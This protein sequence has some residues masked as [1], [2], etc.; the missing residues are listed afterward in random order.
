MSRWDARLSRMVDGD[1]KSFATRD[2]PAVE[3]DPGS[4]ALI[5]GGTPHTHSCKAA[6]TVRDVCGA[7]WAER[8]DAGWRQS[9]TANRCGPRSCTQMTRR[10]CFLARLAHRELAC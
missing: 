9:V 1:A 4:Y 7:G 10:Q 2:T 5:P 3:L 8:H 6:I